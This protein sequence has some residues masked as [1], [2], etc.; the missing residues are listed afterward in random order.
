MSQNNQPAVSEVSI[1]NQALGWLGANPIT[2]LD[3]NGAAAALCRNNYDHCRDAVLESRAWTFSIARA[4]SISED[5]DAW[6]VDY[7]HPRPFDWLRVL[8]VYRG[9]NNGPPKSWP[10][11]SDWRL[12]SGNI[13]TRD[14]HIYLYGQKRVYDTAHWTPMFVQVV[15]ARI[16]ADIAMAL[17]E[18]RKLQV[19][20]WQ[21]YE[22]KLAEAAASDGQQGSNDFITQT[23][24]V[25]VRSG[26]RDTMGWD[27]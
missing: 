21:L 3:E 8:R 13:L 17:T 11:S 26:G 10:L 22:R 16:A 20:M 12:E 19:D 1:S 14:S 27:R 9:R 4:E 23:Q 25:D 2:S 24:L 6:G 5:R 18:N 7:S 15:A